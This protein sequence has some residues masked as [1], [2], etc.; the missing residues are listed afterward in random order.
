MSATNRQIRLAARP[1]GDVKAEDWEHRSAPVEEPGPGRFAG[2]TRFISLDPAMRGWLDDRPSY[3]P[4][5]GIGEV[6]RAGSVIEVTASNH[7]DFQPGDHVVGTFGVQE[8]VVSDGKGALRIDTSLAPP[9]T[10]L[11]ALGMPGMTAY[12][13]LLDVGAL[14]D[15][16]TVVVSGAAG[17]VGTMA[18][19]IAKA[20]GCRVIGIAGGPQKCAL[21]VDELGFDAAIDY[22]AEDVRKALRQ[23]APDGIDVYFDNVGGA[24]LD[25]ALARLAMHGRVVICGAISQYNN[26]TPVEGPSNYL[27][28][29]VRRARMEGFVVF[30][31][32]KRFPQA[33]Q[34]IS[35][36][37]GTG[38]VKVKE[39]VVKGTVD[40]FPE[41]LQMLFRGEN[42]GKLVLELA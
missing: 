9:S 10:Y 8:H 23:H 14:K 20:R 5:V 25:A 2:R 37:I 26:S 35:A 39:H 7:P 34:D 11:G 22:R 36:W 41:V 21:L 18:G 1:T 42:V 15:G 4:P 31:Y 38:R 32:A 29:L 40:D 16:E 33:A 12:F 19:Q 13:G 24:V 6:M 27:S 17:A 28:L 3:L 30:D